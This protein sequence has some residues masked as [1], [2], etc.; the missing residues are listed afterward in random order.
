MI[1]RLFGL[2]RYY[3]HFLFFFGEGTRNYWLVNYLTFFCGQVDCVINLLCNGYTLSYA[4]AKWRHRHGTR[5]ENSEL[6]YLNR[7]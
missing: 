5:R 1:K 3:N 6:Q 7:Q 4:V 2:N